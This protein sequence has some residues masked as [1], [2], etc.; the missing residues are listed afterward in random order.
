MG[1]VVGIVLALVVGVGV[2]MYK[3]SARDEYGHE[4][5][6]QIATYLQDLPDYGTHEALYIEWFENSHE[7][8]FDNNYTLGGRRS[9]GRLDGDAYLDEL[10]EKMSTAAFIAGYKDQAKHLEELRKEVSFQ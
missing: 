9:S 2:V 3:F 10:F 5:H 6:D 1:R 7:E 4:I 8:A